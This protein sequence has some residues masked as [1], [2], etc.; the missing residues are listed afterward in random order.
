MERSYR[1]ND[2]I[3]LTEETRQKLFSKNSVFQTITRDFPVSLGKEISK[4]ERDSNDLLSTLTY[5]E[6]EFISIGEIFETIK[7]RYGGIKPGGIFYDLGSGT[8]KG[9]IAG[10]LLH[11]FD[12]CI[13]IEILEGLYNVSLQLKRVYEET[14]PSEIS[15]R[16]DLWDSKIPEI[17]FTRSDMFTRGW[18]DADF[19]FANSTCFDSSMMLRI[20][21]SEV[22][23]GTWAITLTKS[24]PSSK[25]KIHESIKKLMSWGE[26]T[27]YIQQRVNNSGAELGLDQLEI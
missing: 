3:W 7:E 22:K 14:F 18:A 13:G 11:N 8:G 24:L 5:G 15:T 16:P 23:E 6:L 27:V 19:I 25:W 20:A 21:E 17:E 4:N 2:P 9:V 10:A 12:K 26:A 1:A